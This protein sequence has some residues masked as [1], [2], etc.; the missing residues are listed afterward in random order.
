MAFL[1]KTVRS[2]GIAVAVLF[3]T[4]SLVGIPGVWWANRKAAEITQTGFRLVDTAVG[5]V[6]TGVARMDGLID[7]C[8]AEVRQ[9][10]ETITT[11]GAR[12]EANRPVLNALKERLET[13]LAPR[14]TQMQQVLSPLRDAVGTVG[15]VVSLLNSLPMMADRAPRLAA[16]DEAFNRLEGLSADTMQVCT[17]LRALAAEQASDITPETLAT[18]RGLTQRIDARLG[19]VQS[20]VH[21]VQAD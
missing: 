3:I 6:E 9:A 10:S 16:L 21:E 15:N 17:T 13:N 7:T 20:G 11:V 12:P 4:L 18:L 5:V 1:E 2:G 14:L 19:E 8:R